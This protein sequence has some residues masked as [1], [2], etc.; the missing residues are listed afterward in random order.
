MGQ[1]EMQTPPFTEAAAFCKSVSIVGIRTPAL[2]HGGHIFEQHPAGVRVCIFEF[3]TRPIW[4]PGTGAFKVRCVSM[5]RTSNRRL[6]FATQFVSEE[7]AAVDHLAK[8]SQQHLMLLFL[9]VTDFFLDLP[10]ADRNPQTCC[11]LN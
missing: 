7:I 4:N 3:V 1:V 8:A 9:A 2:T 6:R 11:Q 5:G 10:T